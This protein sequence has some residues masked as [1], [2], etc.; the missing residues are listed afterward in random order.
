MTG[1]DSENPFLVGRH[2][3]DDFAT[4]ADYFSQAEPDTEVIGVD[5]E[6]TRACEGWGYQQR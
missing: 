6:Q 4:W 5:W 3:M 2:R 1:Q